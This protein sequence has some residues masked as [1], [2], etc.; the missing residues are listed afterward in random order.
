[1][2]KLS[3][4]SFFI[5]L[6]CSCKS[7][8]PTTISSKIAADSDCP[9]D[10]NCDISVNAN[11]SLAIKTDEF[12]K[13]YYHLEDN[14]DTKVIVYSYNRTVPKGLQDGHY[15]EEIILEVANSASSIHTSE[16]SSKAT[17]VL[18]GRFCFCKGYTGYYTIQNGTLK[19]ETKEKQQ[20][21]DFTFTVKE[22]P[23][24]ITH[25]AFSLK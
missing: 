2:K 14:K 9:K 6:F 8:S 18:F 13:L 24:I 17:K 1:M 3:L 20:Y 7:N 16:F 11:K 25:I 10:G 23:Q 19:M 12:G 4:V 21:F 15:K 5:L 22:V